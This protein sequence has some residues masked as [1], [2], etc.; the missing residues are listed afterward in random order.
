MATLEDVV[1][2]LK[3][4]SVKITDFK[5]EQQSLIVTM[6]ANTEKADQLDARLERVEQRKRSSSRSPFPPTKEI[7]EE[8][9]TFE[10]SSFENSS[11]S[12][13]DSKELEDDECFDSTGLPRT[14]AP[15]KANPESL[16]R[17]TER[18]IPDVVIEEPNQQEHQLFENSMFHMDMHATTNPPD[19]D[20]N[21][22]DPEIVE[23]EL[24]RHVPFDTGQSAAE[25]QVLIQEEE[26]YNQ[27]HC[28][29]DAP[30][31]VEDADADV[32]LLSQVNALT[33]PPDAA[34]AWV[35]VEEQPIPIAPPAEPPPA[36]PPPPRN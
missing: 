35:G 20:F 12:P 11:P 34:I 29:S 8:K 15:G 10:N 3:A 24:L 13:S 36:E 28:K 33:P 21:I 6:K 18:S 27:Q 31:Y 9:T 32:A 25:D 19:E 7:E 2:M 16:V 4:L 14:P 5:N 30:D 1:E 26:Q 23:V 17:K 22:E